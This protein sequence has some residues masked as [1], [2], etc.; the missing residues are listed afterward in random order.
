MDTHSVTA[1]WTIDGVYAGEGPVFESGHGAGDLVACSVTVN[2]GMEEGPP[3]TASI[4]I[5]NT[6][7]SIDGVAISPA[8]ARATDALTCAWSG[9]TDIDGDPDLSIAS[10]SINGLFAGVGPTLASG[11]IGADVVEH[12][13][14]VRRTRHLGCHRRVHRDCELRPLRR[15]RRD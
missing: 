3:T 5:E 9:F 8:P 15:H 4:T 10:W 13:H 6:L 2:D 14:P 12:G 1:T 7:P 11:H